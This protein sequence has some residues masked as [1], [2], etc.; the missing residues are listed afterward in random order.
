[1]PQRASN[2]TVASLIEL[3]ATFIPVAQMRQISRVTSLDGARIAADVEL[4]AEHW[5][6]AQHFPKDPIFPGSF[7]IEAAGQLIALW[8]W[9]QGL[10]G[11]PRLVRANAEFYRPVTPPIVR[12][13]LR[14]EVRAKRHLQF[15]KV[16]LFAGTTQVASVNAVLAVVGSAS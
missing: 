9:A 4:G 10:R 14:G 6:Y 3:D 16:D 13:G 11:H 8:A 12:L 5:V 2:P 7:M 1:M 15:G